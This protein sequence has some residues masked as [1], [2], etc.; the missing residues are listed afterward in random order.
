[1]SSRKRLSYILN[2]L[3]W[4]LFAESDPIQGRIDACKAELYAAVRAARDAAELQVRE[5]FRS[6][7]R[8]EL[9]NIEALELERMRL[10][11]HAAAG[12][13]FL[14][15]AMSWAVLGLLV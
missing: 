10:F 13:T 5:E 8:Y 2:A 7:A 4:A 15:L 6:I 11:I 14:F 12:L 1:M 9:Q 3:Q